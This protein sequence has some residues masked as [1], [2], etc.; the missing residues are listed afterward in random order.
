MMKRWKDEMMVTGQ[1]YGYQYFS[2]PLGGDNGNSEAIMER[3]LTGKQSNSS[4]RITPQQTA[5][6]ERGVDACHHVIGHDA[7]A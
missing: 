3:S 6:G 1:V 7:P 5:Q 2:I 4:C